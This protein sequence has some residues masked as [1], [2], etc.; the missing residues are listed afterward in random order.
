MPQGS[1]AAELVFMEG[2]VHSEGGLKPRQRSSPSASRVAALPAPR[3]HP[4]TS[5][6]SPPA[7]LTRHP[8]HKAKAKPP[9]TALPVTAEPR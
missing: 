1:P 9:G 2:G 4:Q 3:P 8:A 5:A 7:P 6:A